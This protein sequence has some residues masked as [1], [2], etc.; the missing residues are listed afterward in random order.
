VRDR[1]LYDFLQ[2]TLPR[3]GFR[4]LGFR[5][6]RG[7]VHK[8]L[9]RRM[10]ELGLR[11]TSAYARHIAAQ[12]EELA[13]LDAMCRMTISRF[14]RD[15]APFE[16]LAAAL[17]PE[18]VARARLSGSAR[19]RVWSAGCASGEEAYSM[20]M[21]WWLACAPYAADIGFELIA[22]D[23][24]E[25]VL[26]R[27]RSGRYAAATLREVPEHW[28]H[29]AFARE[30]NEWCVREAF[31]RGVSFERQDLR[32]GAPEGPFDIVLC[33]N[34]AFTYFDDSLQRRVAE[35]I[36][37]RL[38]PGGVLLLGAGE[39]LPDELSGVLLHQGHG[40]YRKP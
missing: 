2:A 30:G 15:H 13:R 31:R 25:H 29:V 27:A 38:V 37:E 32:T 6:V 24:D 40:I 4:W 35:R 20:A 36:L 33:R 16:H 5:R 1:E 34:L 23:L 14:W 18:L 8:R 28:R 17:L 9:W 12:P 19:V 26:E 21:L 22:T 7:T 11:D 3:L 10:R 39:R